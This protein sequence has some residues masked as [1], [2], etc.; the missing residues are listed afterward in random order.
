VK[1]G[2]KIILEKKAKMPTIDEIQM[3]EPLSFVFKGVGGTGKS[4]AMA[5]YGFYGPTLHLDMDKKIRSIKT[6]FDKR[7]AGREFYYE[8]EVFRGN[9][10]GLVKRLEALL[11]TPKG[12]LK[13][14]FVFVDSLTSL[15]RDIIRLMIDGRPGIT[16]PGSGG[17]AGTPYKVL[18]QQNVGEDNLLTEKFLGI[19]IPEIEDYLGESNGI[20]QVLDLLQAIRIKHDAHIGLIAHIV[21]VEIRGIAGAILGYETQLLTAGRKIAAEIPTTWE[22]QYLFIKKGQVDT[23]LPPKFLVRTLDKDD[24]PAATCLA[25]P[26]E[27]DITGKIFF[28]SWHEELKKMKAA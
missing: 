15:A 21:R 10:P 6:Y 25:L 20:I 12:K 23:N 4:V 24:A 14:K 22:E 1:T 2:L 9:Y 17:Q 26:N 7:R 13:Y 19:P 28:D 11:S 16:R 5:S 27:W 8:Y 18:G 3:D